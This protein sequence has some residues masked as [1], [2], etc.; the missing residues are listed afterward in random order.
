MI[1]H[2]VRSRARVHCII[3]VRQNGDAL[4]FMH[5]T[6]HESCKWI[7]ILKNTEKLSFLNTNVYKITK[8]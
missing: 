6:K 2:R 3:N 1:A 7:K 8:K 5:Q 4:M